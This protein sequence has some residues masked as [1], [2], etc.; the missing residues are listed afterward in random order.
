M[1]A[2]LTSKGQI[3]L[4]KP[5]RD[6]LHLQPGDKVEFLVDFSGAV[7]LLPVTQ[8]ISRL[9]GMAPWPRKPLTLEEMDAAIAAGAGGE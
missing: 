1:Q 7:R 8:P 3:T 5:L 6:Q 9:K 2:T 4:P